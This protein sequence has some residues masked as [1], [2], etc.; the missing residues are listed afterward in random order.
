MA[1]TINNNTNA[2]E[3]PFISDQTYLPDQLIAGVFPR[4]TVGNATISTQSAVLPRGTI[5]GQQTVGAI[6]SAAKTGGNTGNGT[7]GTVTAVGTMPPAAPGKYTVNFTAATAFTVTDPNG[8]Q[9]STGVTGTAYSDIVSFTITAGG[10]AFVAGD[11]FVIT[12]AAGTGN[13]IPAVATAVDGSAV[14]SAVLANQTDATGGA[15]NAG[16]YETG[17]F[18]VNYVTY[19]NS[20]TLATLTTLLRPLSIFLKPAV[21]AADPSGE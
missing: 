19:D 15:A 1:L 16:I 8:R 6:T 9:L 7:M 20:F 10:T 11:G 2:F 5:L 18:N 3:Q 13:Y 4:V 14:P 17:E 12:V 21:V